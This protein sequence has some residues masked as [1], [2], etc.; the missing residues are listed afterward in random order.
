MSSRSR[1]G[2][3]AAPSSMCGRTTSPSTARRPLSIS[4]NCRATPRHENSGTLFVTEPALNPD[5]G[6][7]IISARM[8][9]VREGE[10]IGCASVNITFDIL[11]QFLAAQ[12]PSENS[13]T[14]IADAINGQIIAS[15][16]KAKGVRVADGKLQIAR[17]EN[18]EDEDVREAYRLHV[19]TSR[20]EIVFRSPRDGRELSAS[21]ARFTES[22]GHPWQWVTITPT[23]D[24]VGQL[25][26]TNQQIIFIIIGLTAIE[27]LLIFGLARRLSQPIENITRQLESVEALSFGHSATRVS[28]IHEIARLQS[29]TTL[30]SSSLQSFS[31][32]APVDLVKGLVKSGIPLALGVESRQLTVLFSD[33]EGFSTHAERLNIN[34]LLQQTS[35]YFEQ[36]SRAI[37]D[38]KGTVDKFIGDGVMAFWNA[39]MEA[40]EH[41][42]HACNGA[43][44]AVRRMEAVNK[45]WEAEGKARFPHPHRPEQRQLAGRQHRLVRS[46]QLHRHRRRRERRGAA[47]GRQQAVRHRDLHQRQRAQCRRTQRAGTAAAHRSGQGPQAGVHD[48]R[49]A[50]HHRQRRSGT[51]AAADRCKACR[52]DPCRLDRL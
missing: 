6:Y 45:A 41:A 14:L 40:S 20:D 21:F 4:R 38:E 9:I 26:S 12:R 8:P 16:D 22:Y 49:A 50:R 17:L 5:T 51:G 44:R 43:L 2:S 27:L 52:H 47:R 19:Q 24:F 39:P 34:D 7:P 25:K 35:V 33:L 1:T 30:L 29:A 10:F 3:A 46:L 23:D 32:F 31:S 37:A 42:L 13:L 28:K 48:L 36:V 15:S 18:I 11:S